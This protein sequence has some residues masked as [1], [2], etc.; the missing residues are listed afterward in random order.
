[1]DRLVLWN[2]DLTLMDVGKVARDALAEAFRQVTGRPLVALPQLAGRTDTEIF[3]E[4]LYLNDVPP[5]AG[6]EA[7]LLSRYG[8]ALVT[9]FA[10]RRGDLVR[11][12]RLLPGAQAAVL[13]VAELPGVVQ[14]VLTGTIEPNAVCKLQAFG[15]D[16]AL[17]LEIGGYGSDAYPRG[18]LLMRVRQQASEKYGG[19]WSPQTSAGVPAVYIADTERDIEAAEIAGARSIAVATG[20]ATAAELRDAGADLVFTDLSDTGQVIAAVDKLTTVHASR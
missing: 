14:T 11:G 19:A 17:D 12:G 18:S 4:S 16:R 15:L 9:A 1:M 7:E 5:A 8:Q 6:E 20:R 2:I 3:F 13:A 10:A